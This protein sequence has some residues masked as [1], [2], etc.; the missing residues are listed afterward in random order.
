ML[1]SCRS[2]TTDGEEP[3]VDAGGADASGEGDPGAIVDANPGPAIAEDH[4]WVTRTSSTSAFLRGVWC[5]PA[6]DLVVA[7]GYGGAIVRSTDRGATW[8]TVATGITTEL[9][10][11][12]GTGP[13]DVYVVG[14]GGVVL[15]S[16]DAA[17]HF[18]PLSSGQ[19]RRLY[20][21]WGSG[22]HNVFMAGYGDA[23][24]FRSRDEGKTWKAIPTPAISG[25]GKIWGLDATRIYANSAAGVLASHDGGDRFTLALESLAQQNR[26]WAAGPADI[27]TVNKLGVVTRHDETTSVATKTVPTPVASLI[28]VWGTGP[29][30]VY[31]IGDAG[32]IAHSI[33]RGA[34]WTNQ[35]SAS[36]SALYSI[37][38]A[39]GEV[40]TVGE[41]GVIL[42]RSASLAGD[43]GAAD[44]SDG[45]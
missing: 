3:S 36:K 1:S 8:S 17:E 45:G 27:Y 21:I 42:Q 13:G 44:A 5:S 6:A 12:W 30:D 4:P 29:L 43:A 14:D 40:F 19:T 7:V 22:K 9:E 37:H 11:V 23:T 38:G 41:G 15:H 39:D 26:L 20:T 34:T 32:R 10:A 25:I 2:K 18:T 24:I 33:D 16:T 28:D 35:P 31:V